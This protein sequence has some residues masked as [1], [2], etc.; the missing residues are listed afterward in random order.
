[1]LIRTGYNIRFDAQSATP[2]LAM[3]SI[4]PS[5]NKDL[6]TPHRV[7]TTPEVPIY[8]YI[9]SYGNVCSRVTVPSGGLTL[10][11]DFI[12]EDSGEP[13]RQS[14][15]AGQPRLRTCRMTS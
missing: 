7:V 12:I 14:P 10:S 5:R 4:H 13:D 9:D 3:L 8:D 2:L 11:C 6:K 1:M 15:G